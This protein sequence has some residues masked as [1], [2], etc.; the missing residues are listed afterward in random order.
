MILVFHKVRDVEFHGAVD[1]IQNKLDLA[2][3]SFLV[4]WFSHFGLLNR[5]SILLINS[6]SSLYLSLSL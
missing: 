1:V 3:C 2:R 4:I 5:F 6:L